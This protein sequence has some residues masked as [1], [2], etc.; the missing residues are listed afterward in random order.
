MTSCVRF[1]V[2]KQSL[3]KQSKSMY[4]SWMKCRETY[5]HRWT[6]SNN[7]SVDCMKIWQIKMG[8][9]VTRVNDFSPA[10]LTFDL[11]TGAMS[12]QHGQASFRFWCFGNS[13]LSTYGQT[14]VKQTTGRYLITLTFNLYGHRARLWGAS[15]YSLGLPSLKF[16]GLPVPKIC[17]IFCHD[18]NRPSDLEHWPLISEWGHRSSV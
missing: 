3:S 1:A 13:S 5:K 6:I 18:I 10:N 11:Q 15:S 8:S 16:F 9:R 12:P 2:N 14:R 4:N 17:L 7:Y